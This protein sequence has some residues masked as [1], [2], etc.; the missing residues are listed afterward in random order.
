MVGVAVAGFVGAHRHHDVAQRRI[1][2][3]VP[4]L[5]GPFRRRHVGVAAGVDLGQV[6][7][8]ADDRLLLEVPDD[9]VGGARR[10]EV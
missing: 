3:Q 7:R 5:P 9:A 2:G 6:G 8:V 1:R 4:V 10:Y